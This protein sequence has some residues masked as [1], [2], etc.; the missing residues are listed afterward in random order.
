MGMSCGPWSCEINRVRTRFVW[1]NKVLN[2]DE[3]WMCEESSESLGLND[4][5]HR[6]KR[7]WNLLLGTVNWSVPPE[8][9][10]P[11][12]RLSQFKVW[13][14][15]PIWIWKQALIDYQL[16]SFAVQLVSLGE[17]FLVCSVIQVGRLFSFQ[18]PKQ[19]FDLYICYLYFCGI[20]MYIL[21]WVS[22]LFNCIISFPLWAL[23]DLNLCTP[24]IPM[25]DAMWSSL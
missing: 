13:A 7:C 23:T 19:G 2:Q 16:Y 3:G 9:G 25:S 18:L 17:L 12:E 14:L 24:Y 5:Y 11:S 22:H 20:F 4:R 10:T 1:G 8:V 15:A 6:I 21:K